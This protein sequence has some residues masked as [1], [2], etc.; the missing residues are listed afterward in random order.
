MHKCIPYGGYRWLCDKLEA[1]YHVLAIDTVYFRLHAKKQTAPA[2]NS[3]R[4]RLR[5]VFRR[6]SDYRSI[7]YAQRTLRGVFCI[8]PL[9]CI[10][11]GRPSVLNQLYS[12]NQEHAFS[13]LQP[14]T[15]FELLG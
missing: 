13:H 6:P 11:Q 2:G 3:R 9:I 15:R 10:F 5:I 7:A 12:C 1:L 14:V 4:G 8:E